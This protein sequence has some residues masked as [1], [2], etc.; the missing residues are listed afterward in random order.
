MYISD[1]YYSEELEEEDCEDDALPGDEPSDMEDDSADSPEVD[2]NTW[3]PS[4]TFRFQ[5]TRWWKYYKPKLLYDY[6]RVAYLLCPRPTV[7][8]HAKNYRDPQDN[9]AVDRLREKLLVPSIEVDDFK[10]MA[11]SAKLLD[12]FWTELK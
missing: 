1:D 12:K 4:P 11:M 7:I 10:K 9:D 3:N 5:M 2:S 6:V 8:E